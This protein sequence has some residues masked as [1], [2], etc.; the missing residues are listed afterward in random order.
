MSVQQIMETSRP[1]TMLGILSRFSGTASSS[2][3]NVSMTCSH[4]KNGLILVLSKD[5]TWL[6][7]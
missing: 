1:L 7:E 4:G 2:N 5:V 3:F 6:W